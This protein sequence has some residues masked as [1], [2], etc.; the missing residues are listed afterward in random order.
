MEAVDQRM[1]ARFGRGHQRRKVDP[2]RISRQAEISVGAA[3]LAAGIVSPDGVAERELVWPIIN[4]PEILE[5][6]EEEL[7]ALE[8][9]DP[10]LEALRDAIV[11]WYGE[12]GHLDPGD[13]KAHLSR[14]GFASE[15]GQLSARVPRWGAAER[16]LGS[17]LEAWRAGVAQRRR[18]A[19]RRERAHAA[20]AAIAANRD[21][22]AADRVLAVNRLINPAGAAGAG[23]V[24]T[25]SAED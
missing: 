21:G 4:H 14:I 19:E 25:K 16:D 17:V 24:R 12:R 22:E 7:A 23:G 15:I 6:I 11:S 5:V 9:V 20:E 18:L 13:L 8:L 2:T 3:R 1:E 10:Q